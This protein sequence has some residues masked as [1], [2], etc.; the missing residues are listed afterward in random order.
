VGELGHISVSASS[1]CVGDTIRVTAD[2]FAPRTAVTLEID[3]PGH[4][5]GVT[6]ANSAGK[7]DVRV[8]LF[9]HGPTGKH[10]LKAIG[11]Q[12]GGR[13]LTLSAP[14]TIKNEAQCRVEGEG[15]TTTTAPGTPDT[16]TGTTA[17]GSTTPVTR[18]GGKQGGGGGGGGGGTPLGEG[19]LAFT[20]TDAVDLA[21]IGTA[22]AI[23]GRALYGLARSSDDEEVEE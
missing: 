2:G 11:V 12:T 19:S 6:T 4:V 10:T 23:G 14:I 17:P 18:A 22:A 8:K 16:T 21:L 20:G 5:L 15:S 9:D 7:I 1:P 13:T 3:S